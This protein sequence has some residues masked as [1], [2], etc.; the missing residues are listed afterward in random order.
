MKRFVLSMAAGVIALTGLGLFA[1]SAS[2]HPA[3]CGPVRSYRAPVHRKCHW[4]HSF[5]HHRVWV[6]CRPPC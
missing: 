2:A 5:Y 4:G 1:S 6:K 3:P